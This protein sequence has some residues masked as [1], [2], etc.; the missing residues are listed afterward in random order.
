MTCDQDA[1]PLVVDELDVLAGTVPSAAPTTT[2][3]ACS[4]TKVSCAAAQAEL[5]EALR[6]G[7]WEQVAERR[8]EMPVPFSDFADFEQRM[9][10]PTYAGHGID[11]AK[12]A[13]ARAAFEPQCGPDGALFTR[14]MHVHLLRRRGCRPPPRELG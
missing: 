11:D 9:M 4:M 13:E 3:S 5:D 14:P 1:T 2:W 6:S 7:A 10:R 12:L 8:F